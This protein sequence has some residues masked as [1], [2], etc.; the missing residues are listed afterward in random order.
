MS[1]VYYPIF[2]NDFVVPAPSSW[3][4]CFWICFYGGRLFEAMGRMDN[5]LREVP[6]PYVVSYYTSK[7][8]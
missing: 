8:T 5:Q 3:H 1:E 2:T 4:L 7:E 6:I